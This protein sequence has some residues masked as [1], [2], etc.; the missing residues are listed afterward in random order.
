MARANT[1]GG[2]KHLP[3]LHDLL[4]TLNEVHGYPAGLAPVNGEHA[5]RL[6]I[7][8]EI[9]RRIGRANST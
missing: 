9:L 8:S 4:E 2:G 7:M 6:A 1:K 3:V 5:L